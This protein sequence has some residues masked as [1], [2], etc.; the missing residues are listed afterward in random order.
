MIWCKPKNFIFFETRRTSSTSMSHHI[1]FHCKNHLNLELADYLR[2]SLDPPPFPRYPRHARA[3]RVREFLGEEKFD[4]IYT[5]AMERNPFEKAWSLYK[6]K[7]GRPPF[8]QWLKAA[9]RVGTISNSAYAHNNTIIV[10]EV[11]RF[12]DIAHKHQVLRRFNIPTPVPYHH[13]MTTPVHHRP[14]GYY[15]KHYDTEA[16]DIIEEQFAW[17]L[18]HFDW[19]F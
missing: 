3:M 10:S 9:A 2:E 11:I 6:L 5:F 16:R 18:E 8:T 4:K 17:E 15:R 14:P 12:E 1:K 7:K 13:K 19:S